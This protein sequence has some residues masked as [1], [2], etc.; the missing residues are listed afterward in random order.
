MRPG[1]RGKERKRVSIMRLFVFILS[2]VAGR[3]RLA[4]IDIAKQFAEWEAWVVE[5]KN[6][7]RKR[8]YDMV[9]QVLWET[10]GLADFVVVVA[11]VDVVSF[12]ILVAP[13]HS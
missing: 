11:V 5:K 1:I 10:W 9:I 3:G 7:K 8:G 4:D 12:A 6:V 2:S 13:G